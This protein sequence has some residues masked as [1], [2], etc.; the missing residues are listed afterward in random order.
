MSHLCF[1]TIFGY[2]NVIGQCR[3][4]KVSEI[5]ADS[6]MGRDTQL[7]TNTFSALELDI[8]TLAIVKTQRVT[9][10]ALVDGDSQRGG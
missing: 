2:I 8:V 7:I 3:A 6:L 5:Q 9:G 10:K 4:P 1:I